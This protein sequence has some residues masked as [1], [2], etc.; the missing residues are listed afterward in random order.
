MRVPS[1][2]IMIASPRSTRMRAVSIASSSDSPRR[3]GNAPRAFRNQ[4][5]QRFSNS[6][7]FATK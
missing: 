1:G 3:I 4:P 6:S 5:I 2:K 7:R